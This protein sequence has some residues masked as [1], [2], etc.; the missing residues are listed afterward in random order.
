MNTNVLN[1]LNQIYQQGILPACEIQDEKVQKSSDT[2]DNTR[3]FFNCITSING[4]SVSLFAS[5]KGGFPVLLERRDDTL[6]EMS[7][8]KLFKQDST[9]FKKVSDAKENM[10][11]MGLTEE[12]LK[13]P[14]VQ[15]HIFFGVINEIMKNDPFFTGT[16]SERAHHSALFVLDLEESQSISS[17]EGCAE[18]STHRIHT[19]KIK[20]VILSKKTFGS[21]EKEISIPEEKIIW[22]DS[23][24]TNAIS[25]NG[26]HGEMDYRSMLK[27]PQLEV[28]NY[29]EGLEQLLEKDKSCKT[30][31]THIA[32]FRN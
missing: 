9:I 2:H 10:L 28:P 14:T 20:Y 18:N 19:S 7:A 30:L 24:K 4:I 15:K 26:Y 23:T 5:S 12:K 32:R 25:F 3:V 8:N 27:M 29:Q 21:F 6:Y 1:T 17:S 13:N 16:L 31:F 11:K 22:V